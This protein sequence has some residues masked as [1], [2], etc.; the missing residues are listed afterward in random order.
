[1]VSQPLFPARQPKSDKWLYCRLCDV[2]VRVSERAAHDEEEQHAKRLMAF[3]AWEVIDRATGR[4]RCPG[5]CGWF[6]DPS[7]AILDNLLY[8]VLALQRRG[9]RMDRGVSPVAPLAGR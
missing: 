1:M 9:H 8:D 3:E 5:P 7:V 2:E 6:F 4:Y